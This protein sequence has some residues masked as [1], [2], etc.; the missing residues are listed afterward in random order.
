MVT[1][2]LIVDSD[3]NV[4]SAFARFFVDL[5]V[6]VSTAETLE[7]GIHGPGG[8]ADLILI[9]DGITRRLSPEDA[10]EIRRRNFST[11]TPVIAMSGVPLSREQ[12]AA[13]GYA[14]CL[15]K[16]L[17]AVRVREVLRRWVPELAAA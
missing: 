16:P 5:P 11:L 13:L 1:R 3:P 4:R 10:G 14:D 15:L 12:S 7:Q 6:H 9:D 2:I 8:V 17:A